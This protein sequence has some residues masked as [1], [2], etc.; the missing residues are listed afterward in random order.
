[1]VVRCRPL[2]SKEQNDGRKRIVDMDV[3]AGQVKVRASKGV[4]LGSA[5]ACLLNAFTY[6][7]SCISTIANLG[8]RADL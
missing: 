8:V 5:R 3:D 7:I 2:N 6:L 1:V 4:C